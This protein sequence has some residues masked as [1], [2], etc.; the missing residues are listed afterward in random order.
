MP[1]R[2]PLTMVQNI[3]PFRQCKLTELLFSNSFP[4]AHQAQHQQQ[5]A[6]KAVMIVTADARGDFNATTQ[7]LRYSALARE[8]TV[9]RI[10]SVTSTILSGVGGVGALSRP[11]SSGRAC[12][13]GGGGSGASGLLSPAETEEELADLRAANAQLADDA[14]ILRM[15][16][17]DETERRAAAERS[18]RAVEERLAAEEDGVR[19]EVCA[20]MDAALAAERARWRR[21]WE[22]EAGWGERRVDRKI[23]ILTRG[24]AAAEVVVL[25]DEMGRVRE[26]EDEN[27]RLRAKVEALERERLLKT[28]SAVGKKQ[29]VLKAKKW[30]AEE[31]SPL[32]SP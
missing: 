3:V 2:A 8:I 11:T 32:G 12:A 26:L 28:P 9:P 13:C 25:E 6:Q 19:A 24:G 30:S 10:P 7:I 14:E 15:R 22:D 18:W 23:E 20:Q 4:S 31:V 17:A 5:P 29:R 16:L 1:G 21:A 27:D